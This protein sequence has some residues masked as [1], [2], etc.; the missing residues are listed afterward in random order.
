M[1]PTKV[2]KESF[3]L[4]VEQ[5]LLIMQLCIYVICRNKIK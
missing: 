2:L 3:H 4:F 1:D 5:E